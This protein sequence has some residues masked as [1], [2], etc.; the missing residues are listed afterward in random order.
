MLRIFT[1]ERVGK[2]GYR[3][4]YDTLR[5]QFDRYGRPNRKKLEKHDVMPSAVK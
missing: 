2:N 3:L 1:I 5:K 4:P